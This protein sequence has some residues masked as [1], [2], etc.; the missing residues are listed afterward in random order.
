MSRNVRKWQT[1]SGNQRFMPPDIVI[2]MTGNVRQCPEMPKTSPEHRSWPTGNEAPGRM[3]A[4][5]FSQPT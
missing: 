4:R 3:D 2:G 1:S 5:R